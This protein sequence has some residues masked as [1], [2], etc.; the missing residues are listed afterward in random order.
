[1]QNEINCR[2][3]IKLH[4]KKIV[5][6]RIQNLIANLHCDGMEEMSWQRAREVTNA[7]IDWSSNVTP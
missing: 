6:I 5:L 2:Q 7:K 1:M 3:H 4:I